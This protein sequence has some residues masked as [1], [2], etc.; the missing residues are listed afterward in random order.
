MFRLHCLLH[1]P[2]IRRCLGLWSYYVDCSAIKISF[3]E[4]L[5]LQSCFSF[6]WFSH[7]PMTHI[8]YF[9]TIKSIAYKK[10]YQRDNNS[11]AANERLYLIFASSSSIVLSAL[12]NQLAIFPIRYHFAFTFCVT[13]RLLIAKSFCFAPIKCTYERLYNV[14]LLEPH[15]SFI[16]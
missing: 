11:E 2:G 3:T 7:C 16:Y 5:L 6:F 14:F 13:Y 1:S 15:D 8:R 10:K 4:K 9:E 12:C